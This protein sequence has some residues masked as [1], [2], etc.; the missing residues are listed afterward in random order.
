MD[1]RQLSTG[2]RGIECRNQPGAVATW[3]NVDQTDPASV[4]TCA[5]FPGTPDPIAYVI[6][7]GKPAK[8]KGFEWDITAL[9]ADG[10]RIDWSGGYNKF[11]S[12]VTTAGQPGYLAPGNHRQP[13]WNM[14][15]NVSYDVETG[16]GTFTPR[17]DWSWQSQQDYDPTPQTGLPD[18][19]YVIPAYSLFNGQIAYK[20]PDKDWSATLEVTNLA[21]R[22]YHYQLLIGTIN[23][24]QRVGPP[25]EFKL[26]VRKEF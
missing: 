23:G 10:F 21:N 22:Y 26:T 8:L 17:I 5:Q 7:I 25:R 18:P 6:N 3:F 11:E 2:V 9:P 19:L 14:H 13:E 16:V 4:T 1:Y 20:S 24:Y 12:G 15:A